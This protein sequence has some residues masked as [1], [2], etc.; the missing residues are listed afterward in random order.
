MTEDEAK[1]WIAARGDV[2][3]ETLVSIERYIALLLGENQRQNLIARSTVDR[4]WARHI[5]DSIQ[6]VDYLR[7]DTPSGAPV[8]DLGSGPGLPGLVLA[9]VRDRA[10]KLVESRKRRC[11]FLTNATGEL[12]LKNVSV[13][14]HDL[15]TVEPFAVSAIIARAFA[16][17][18]DLIDL[19]RPFSNSATRWILPRG[20]KGVKEWQELPRRHKAMFHVERSITEQQ[21]VILV[22]EG[23]A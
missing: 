19:A 3:H 4:I 13:I 8:I 15:K 12:G 11:A 10:F 7:S 23:A 5:V 18:S 14:C 16:P 1:A 17:L 9:I 22:G 20:A 21:A 6:L 2:P